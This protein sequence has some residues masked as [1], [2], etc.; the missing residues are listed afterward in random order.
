MRVVQPAKA[1]AARAADGWSVEARTRESM[2]IAALRLI[3]AAGRSGCVAG[4]RIAY[5]PV[6]LAVWVHL[7]TGDDPVSRVEA[8]PEGWLWAA[9]IA[10]RRTSLMLFCDARVIKER[11]RR[12]DLERWLRA[13]LAKTVLFSGWTR[14]PFA[15]AVIVCDA[16][17]AYAPAPIGAGYLK[18]GDA[19]FTLDPLSSTGVEKALQ[20]AIAGAVVT[21]TL[22]QH[23]ERHDLCA[24]FYEDRQRDAV[25]THAA[26]TREYYDEVQ[27]Y[28]A[29]PF[30]AVR[31]GPA[32]SSP[33]LLARTP[34]RR[35]AP[36]STTAVRLASD[37]SIT[38]EPCIV[39]DT[40]DLRRA[41][42]SPA[43]S[44]PLVFLGGVEVAPLLTDVVGSPKWSALLD[45]WSRRMPASSAAR[46]AAWLWD[47]RVLCEAPAD[48]RR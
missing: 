26:W 5:A 1:V 43:L 15:G 9:P 47:R 4:R 44:R 2:S 36:D 32:P 40:I 20:T 10:E 17:C 24:R 28:A 12:R 16:T 7:E 25:A 42:R 23:P 6:T 38:E 41:L 30:W 31:L 33:A 34:E 14:V 35:D 18:I 13:R 46:L 39:G 37:V 29:E 3:D 8:I 22:L 19:N 21:H 27:R 11:T 48:G 45:R